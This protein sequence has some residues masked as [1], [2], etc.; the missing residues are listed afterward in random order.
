MEKGKYCAQQKQNVTVHWKD[1][2]CML[3]FFRRAAHESS[4]DA[5]TNGQEATIAENLSREGRFL[6]EQQRKMPSK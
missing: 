1:F 5:A 6:G 2:V 4:F 3:S